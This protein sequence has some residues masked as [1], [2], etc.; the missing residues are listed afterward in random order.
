MSELTKISFRK[1]LTSQLENLRLATRVWVAGCNLSWHALT[2]TIQ[3]MRRF[4]AAGC[5]LYKLE[6]TEDGGVRIL[7]SHPFVTISLM[8]ESHDIIDVVVRDRKN[9]GVLFEYDGED[10]AQRVDS[11]FLN[12]LSYYRSLPSNIGWGKDDYA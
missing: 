6:S 5:T 11:L 2:L 8:L 12:P 3:A 9:L 10:F 7:Y 4:E 1:R